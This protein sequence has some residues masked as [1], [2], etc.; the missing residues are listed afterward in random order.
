MDAWIDGL[1]AVLNG[2]GFPD[3]VHVTLV[4][5]PIG[6]VIGAFILSWIA[7]LTRWKNAAAGAHYCSRLALLFLI[8]V[9]LTGFM[10]WRHFYFG[11]WLTPVKLKLI[12]GIL[13]LILSALIVAAGFR[14]KDG[15]RTAAVL[16]ALSVVAVVGLGWYGARIVY[17]ERPPLSNTYP[18]GNAVFAANCAA[19]H[20][21]GSNKFEPGAPLRGSDDL[22]RFDKF[23]AQIRRPEHIMPPFAPSRLSDADARALYDYV[24]HEV[25]CPPAQSSPPRP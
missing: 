15:W 10:D 5:I 6:L 11:A 22:Q 25:D 2:M 19:C 8:P 23:L 24:L 4:H 20:A 14:W 18:A 12:L 9:I 21:G 7:W 16:G 13:L 3:P 1:Y 17:G